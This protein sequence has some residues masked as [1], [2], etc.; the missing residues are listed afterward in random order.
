MHNINNRNNNNRRNPRQT[1]TNNNINNNNSSSIIQSTPTLPST[2]PLLSSNKTQLTTEQIDK[3]KKVLD[4]PISNLFVEFKQNFLSNNIEIDSIRL[5]GGAASYVLTTD[6]DFVYRD[7][8]ILFFV[9]SPLNSEQKTNL[10]SKSES[11]TCDV[12]TI[13]KYIVCECLLSYFINN[14]QDD[15]S[16]HYI[17]S[18]IDAYSNKNIKITHDNDSW[19]LLSLQ[20]PS[21]QNLELK[22]VEKLKRQWQFSVDSFQIVLDP[23]LTFSPTT[24]TKQEF[25]LPNTKSICP[26]ISSITKT[27]TTKNL[28]VQAIN[29]LNIIKR[30]QQDLNDNSEMNVNSDDGQ[31]LTFGF[32]T[33]LSRSPILSTL[34]DDENEQEETGKCQTYSSTLATIT[35]ISNVSDAYVNCLESKEDNDE[36]VLNDNAKKFDNGDNLLQFHISVHEND[37][38]DD[39][40]VMDE[41]DED[42]DDNHTIFLTPASPPTTPVPITKAATSNDLI[43]D[44][45]SV[46]NDINAAINHLNNKLISTYEPEQMRGGGLLKYCNLLAR[47]FVPADRLTLSKME[48]YM[49]S[50]FF[51]DYKSLD[52]QVYILRGYIESHFARTISA[53]TVCL[54]KDDK[55]AILQYIYHL[56]RQYFDEC[57]RLSLPFDNRATMKLQQHHIYYS[58]SSSASSTSSGS[59]SSSPQRNRSYNSHYYYQHHR[60]QN[61]YV[62]ASYNSN[63]INNNNNT[64]HKRNQMSNINVRQQHNKF[65]QQNLERKYHS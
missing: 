56:R 50:R 52:E 11:H 62:Y 44:V 20:N 39:G 15:Y 28:T 32:F 42:D 65:P 53:S 8:D 12:W 22:F 13:I 54:F 49:C 24:L 19:A 23:L 61:Q 2:L 18:L 17:S 35:T 30:Q 26:S 33:P 47:G 45:Y 4:R 14:K 59:R 40:I 21:G 10:F 1:I 51:I 34:H 6:D 60:N 31:D 9:K 63:N 37:S 27:I 41:E 16:H 57:R 3:L 64:F 58:S 55:G 5:N 7:L 43:I 36:N 46:Y 38:S 29:G 48:K 25:I